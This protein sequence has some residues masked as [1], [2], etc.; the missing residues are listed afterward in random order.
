MP[1]DNFLAA[2]GVHVAVCAAC[3]T[4]LRVGEPHS[5]GRTGPWI[6]DIEP[7]QQCLEEAREPKQ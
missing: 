4:T 7:C 6:I 1:N 3:G 5:E 2:S